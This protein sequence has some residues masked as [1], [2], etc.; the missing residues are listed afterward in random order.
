MPTIKCSIV[1][2]ESLLLDNAEVDSVVVPGFDGEVGFLP[3]HARYLGALGA[4]ELRVRMPGN[5]VRR[6]F[7]SGGFAQVAAGGVSVVTDEA[8]P[9]ERLAASEA[10][11][12][13]RMDT[14]LAQKSHTLKE[15]EARAADLARLRAMLTVIQR[16]R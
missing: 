1:T 15:E 9:A 16:A 14:L 3:Q 10:T 2:P 4:G 6:W 13:A 8:V 7:V 12:R 11:L 5:T